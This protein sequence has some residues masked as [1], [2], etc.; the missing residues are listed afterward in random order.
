[1]PLCFSFMLTRYAYNT[2]YKLYPQPSMSI[3]GDRARELAMMRET[4]RFHAM[5]SK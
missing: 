3:A 2:P 1:M 5:P 4:R